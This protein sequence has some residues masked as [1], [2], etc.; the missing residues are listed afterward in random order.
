MNVHIR[1][2]VLA[3]SCTQRRSTALSLLS[4]LPEAHNAL[5]V[6]RRRSISNVSRLFITLP[7]VSHPDLIFLARWRPEGYNPISTHRP[8]LSGR[9]HLIRIHTLHLDPL[10]SL[11]SPCRSDHPIRSAYRLDPTGDPVNS[12]YDTSSLGMGLLVPY[13]G[14]MTIVRPVH[15]REAQL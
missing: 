3:H 5:P 4:L 9:H 7:N 1:Q 2:R 11:F 8:R 10:P 12:G 6:S 13:Q 14:P 15:A